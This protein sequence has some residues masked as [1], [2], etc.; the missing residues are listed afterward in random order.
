[1]T[2]KQVPQDLPIRWNSTYLMLETAIGQRE[3][4]TLLSDIDPYFDCLSNEE[5]DEVKTIADFLK[6]FYDITVFFSGSTYPT[7]NLYFSGVWRIH[8]KIKEVAC[9]DHSEFEKQNQLCCMA[10][11]M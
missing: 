6:P 2:S 1:M 8:M 4:F 11:R 7:A 5:W 3:A 9:V 10:R